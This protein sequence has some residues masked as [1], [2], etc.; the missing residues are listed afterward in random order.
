MGYLQEVDSWLTERLNQLLDEET[1]AQLKREL[2]QVILDSYHNGK[3]SERP[4][5]KKRPQQ[6]RAQSPSGGKK[7]SKREVGFAP[8]EPQEPSGDDT[9]WKDEEE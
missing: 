4:W 1:A 2:K 8:P 7:R 5:Y 6:R 9:E 3:G